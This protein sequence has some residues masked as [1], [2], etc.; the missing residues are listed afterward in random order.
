MPG[1]AAA[2]HGDPLTGRQR[3][4]GQSAPSRRPSTR[5]SAGRGSPQRPRHNRSV[6]LRPRAYMFSQIR[7]AILIEYA[8]IAIE[9]RAASRSSCS[10]LITAPRFAVCSAP[11][12]EPT[13]RE[14]G[15]IRDA[16]RIIFDGLLRGT[17]RADRRGGPRAAGRR[18][19]RRRGSRPGARRGRGR[20]PSP[21]SGPGRPSSGSSTATTSTPTS[22]V[23]SPSSSRRSSAS[24]PTATP[25]ST[26]ARSSGSGVCRTGCETRI[27]SCCSS[28]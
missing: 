24:T 5:R 7:A 20:R 17:G 8:R 25:S 13:P 12:G 3:T 18:A 19:V 11:P 6:P 15:R 2:D 4:R 23:S 1:A 10:L 14:A 16:K 27:E 9:Y 21:A 22:G 26:G 28:S